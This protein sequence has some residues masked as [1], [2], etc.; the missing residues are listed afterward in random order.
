MAGLSVYIAFSLRFVPMVS[1]YC[2]YH[3]S[4]DPS[5][6]WYVA[7]LTHQVYVLLQHRFS[8]DKLCPVEMRRTSPCQPLMSL[9]Q[10]INF[11]KV[12]VPVTHNWTVIN[13]RS[14]CM[15]CL[16]TFFFRAQLACHSNSSLSS[17]FW[18]KHCVVQ[19]ISCPL[20]SP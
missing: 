14:F 9:W 6:Y 15:F 7:S 4:D 11:K 10:R 17:N 8:K 13:A 1:C 3:S 20:L 16:W 5:C 19:R 18:D 12:V 2:V